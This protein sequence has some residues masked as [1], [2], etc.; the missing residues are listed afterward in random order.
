ML[1]KTKR[2][3]K[4]HKRGIALPGRIITAGLLILF[5]VA[6]WLV[7]ELYMTNISRVIYFLIQFASLVIVFAI[8]NKRD[9]PS[10]KMM[11]VIFIFLFMALP[12]SLNLNHNTFS[13]F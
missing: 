4:E 8:L 9:N 2:T 11:W 13:K 5:Q 7:I 1:K 3:K 12:G 6:V 10:Y